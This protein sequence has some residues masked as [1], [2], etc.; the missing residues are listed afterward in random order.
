MGAR[1]GGGG[2]MSGGGATE[3]GYSQQMAAGVVA[4][5]KSIM[6]NN[7]ETLKVFDDQGNVVYEKQGGAHSVRYDGRY[8]IDK[9][10]THNHPSG[11]SFSG[12]DLKTAVILNQ[13][14]IRA[15]GKEYTYS[16][17]RPAGGWGKSPK[18]VITKW[19]KMYKIANKAYIMNKTGDAAINRRMWIKLTTDISAKIA[20]DYGWNFSV[21]KNK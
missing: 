3:K 11:S 12:T 5:E 20:K 6:G 17:K 4:A 8:A 21:K 13:K 18:A 14:E 15:V 7:Y 19:N 9:V 10:V 2:G 1:S 16:M